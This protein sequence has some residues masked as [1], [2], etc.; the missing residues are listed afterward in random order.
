MALRNWMKCEAGKDPI[1]KTRKGSRRNGGDLLPAGS[2][3]RNNLASDG[4]RKHTRTRWRYCSG[5][6]QRFIVMAHIPTALTYAADTIL[7]ALYV[8]THLTHTSIHT[9]KQNDNSWA[10]TLI[11]SVLH[12]GNKSTERWWSARSVTANKGWNPDSNPDNLPP[13][14]LLYTWEPATSLLVVKKKK[15]QCEIT[16]KY[17]YQDTKNMLLIKG[18]FHNSLVFLGF[19]FQDWIHQGN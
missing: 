6:Y 18:G 12:M 10:G 1:C 11:V 19:Q 2:L 4:N 16:W 15:N 7:S 5:Y 9:L 13:Q 17:W 8:L 3:S 14:P